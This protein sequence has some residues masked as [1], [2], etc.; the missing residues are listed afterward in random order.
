MMREKYITPEVMAEARRLYEETLAPVEDIRAMMGLAGASFYRRVRNHGWRRRHGHAGRSEF[1]RSLTGTAIAKLLPPSAELPRAQ[2]AANDEPLTPQ[3]R[4]A[5]AHH[6]MA[7]TRDVLDAV[8][9]VIVNIAPGDQAATDH[10]ART[11]ASVS[12]SL[13]DIAAL[14]KPEE[15]TPPDEADDDPVPRD[16]DEFRYELARRIRGFIEARRLGAGGVSAQPEAKM[17]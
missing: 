13:R 17:E 9:R 7:T 5:L 11:L 3:Q 10:C 14:N 2:L 8:Q 16:M 15:V 12:R 6:I 1:P 4:N